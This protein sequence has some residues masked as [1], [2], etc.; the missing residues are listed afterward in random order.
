ML[1]DGAIF[2]SFG[3]EEE[4]SHH[5]SLVVTFAA[6][7]RIAIEVRLICLLRDIS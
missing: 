6:D 2:K 7:C 4:F 5:I 1:D 3:E